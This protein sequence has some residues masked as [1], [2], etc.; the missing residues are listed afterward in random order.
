MTGDHPTYQPENGTYEFTID[1]GEPESVSI[2]VIEA[3]AA[4]EECD[5][6]DLP[7]L[8]ATIDPDGL[9]SIFSPRFGGLDRVAGAVSFYYVDYEVQID[10]TG[11]VTMTPINGR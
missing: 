8:S 2:A 3:I 5:E 10:A 7:P 9:D 6:S 11:T 4:I 1:W